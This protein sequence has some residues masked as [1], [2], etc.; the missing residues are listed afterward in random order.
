M[1]LR[2]ALTTAVAGTALAMAAV[3]PAEAAPVGGSS[4]TGCSTA[5]GVYTYEKTGETATYDTYDAYFDITVRDNCSGDGW[6][7]SLYLSYRKYSGGVWSWKSM[8][9]V[10][11]NGTY[12]TT[13]HNVQ[14]VQINVCDY[15]PDRSPR[16]CQRVY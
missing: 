3:A 1:R 13:L 14:G 12:N 10:K 4:S 7:G 6:A 2:H 5:S 15:Y 8:Q 16:G 9:R 11:T